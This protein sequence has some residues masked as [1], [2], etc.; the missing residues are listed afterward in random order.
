[1]NLTVYL[2]KFDKFGVNSVGENSSIAYILEFD[3][4]YPHKLHKL[5][6]EYIMA[7][8]KLEISHNMFSN[9]C[10]SIE[11]EYDNKLIN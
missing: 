5:H 3:L 4:E 1:M 8:Q 2:K 7:P 10:S 9:Y 11:N 6:N